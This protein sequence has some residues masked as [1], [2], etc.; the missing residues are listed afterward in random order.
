MTSTTTI[1]LTEFQSQTPFS[2]YHPIN[3][4]TQQ[5][6]KGKDVTVEDAN[7]TS[8]LSPEA[9]P[10]PSSLRIALTILQPCLVNFFSSFSSGIITV[11]LP[12]IAE[13]L[14]I[15]DSLYLWPASVF[16]LTCGATLLIAGSITDLIGARNVEIVAIL[17]LSIFVLAQSV[18]TSGIQ[19]I[20][21]RAMQ[22]IGLAIHI[23]ASVSLIAAGVPEGKP[24]NFAFA[25]Y[26]LSQPLGFS[27]GLVSSG[28]MIQ[29]AGWRSAFYLSAAG[30]FVAA[31]PAFWILPK[32][33][34]NRQ[35]GRSLW[36]VLRKDIDWIGGV[37]ASGCLAMLA[38][39]LA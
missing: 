5:N 39:V 38:Y 14:S 17:L 29:K 21:F 7:P 3:N 22:G 10:T 34:G 9:S 2:E 25:C 20:V 4:A 18:S 6:I 23:P 26:G 28:I 19:F 12:A 13:S 35:P 30:L 36:T 11:G 1:E 32:V 24:R 15:P 16:G 8:A 37:L 31:I 27:V 33:K